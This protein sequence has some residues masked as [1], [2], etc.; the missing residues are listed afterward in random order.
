MLGATGLFPLMVC[1]L[2]GSFGVNGFGPSGSRPLLIYSLAWRIIG[3]Q[4]LAIRF[5]GELLTAQNIRKEHRYSIADLTPYFIPSGECEMNDPAQHKTRDDRRRARK[6]ERRKQ[7]K[8]PT[9]LNAQ[10]DALAER[11]RLDFILI[12]VSAGAVLCLI[13]LARPFY[14]AND[15]SRWS[16]VYSLAERGTYNIDETPW[17][18]TIDRCQLNGHYYSEKPPLLPTLLA[19][20]YLLLKKLSFGRL[21]FRNSPESVVRVILASINLVPLVIFLGLFSRLLDRLAPDPW[22]RAY[23]MVAAGLGT[24]LTGFSITLNN[25]TI[26]A[27]SLFFALYPAFLIWCEGQR[28]GRLFAVA[29]FFAG[30]AAVNDYPAA[31]FL[32]ALGAGLAWKARRQ[33]LIWFLPFALLPLAGHFWTNYLVTGDL[34]PAYLHRGALIFPGSYWTIDP[35]SGRAVGRGGIDNI[36]EPWPV[37]LFHMLV[38][39]HGILSLS[40]IFIFTLMGVWSSLRSRGS[41]LRAF[42]VLAVFLTL[43]LLVFYTFFAGNRIY[44]GMCCGLRFFFWLIP[45]W[46]MLLPEGLRGKTTHRWFRGMALAFLLISAISVFYCARNPWSRPWIHEY[47]HYRHWID[48]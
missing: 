5:L 31:A 25:H 36:Y 18:T 10:D 8:V 27:F 7:L 14:G 16:T 1:W 43:V 6:K 38:G 3:F 40:P 19:G 12:A 22:I 34:L 44:G 42:A 17:P 48:Y 45:L 41:P 11:R 30:F 37:Y 15:L 28:T 39:H 33:T 47:L 21:S 35:A 9:R 46:L 26:T 2:P 29:G 23:T 13:L 4:T 32:V 20:E 24:F